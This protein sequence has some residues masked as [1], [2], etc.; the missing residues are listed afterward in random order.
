[1]NSTRATVLT[2]YLKF[3]SQYLASSG[4]TTSTKIAGVNPPW[5]IVPS[6]AESTGTGE[7]IDHRLLP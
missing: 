4:R 5:N 7:S 2:A 6:I 1:M 3:T